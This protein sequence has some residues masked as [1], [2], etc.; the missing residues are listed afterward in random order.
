MSLPTKGP[1]TI[2]ASCLTHCL[3]ESIP[4]ATNKGIQFNVLQNHNLTEETH[5]RH[6]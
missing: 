2:M 4:E 5:D 3:L 6:W 1:P